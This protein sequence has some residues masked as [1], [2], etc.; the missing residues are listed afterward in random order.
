MSKTEVKNEERATG[1]KKPYVSPELIEFGPIEKLTQSGA[2]SSRSDSG[3]N[4]MK[5]A[6]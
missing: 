5:P 6:G 4:M 3:S 2:A 1:V